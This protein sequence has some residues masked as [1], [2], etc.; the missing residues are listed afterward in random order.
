M[1]EV[2]SLKHQLWQLRWL[3]D[4]KPAAAADALVVGSSSSSSREWGAAVA[5]TAPDS[6][7]GNCDGCRIK[8]QQQ[9]QLLLRLL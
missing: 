7:C 9:E 3:Q 8:S 5:A 1:A 6:S 2:H 4:Q